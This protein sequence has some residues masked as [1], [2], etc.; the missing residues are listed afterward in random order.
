MN[1]LN[2]EVHFLND[3]CILGHNSFIILQLGLNVLVVYN[4]IPTTLE[5]KTQFKKKR[6]FSLLANHNSI[7]WSY[8][9]FDNFFFFSLL[10]G[11]TVKHENKSTCT[12]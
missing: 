12:R 10:I 8:F 5:S 1:R 9:I 11:A 7:I 3:G 6:D 2:F 4:S